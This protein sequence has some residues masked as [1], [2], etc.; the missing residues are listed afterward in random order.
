MFTFLQYAG[1]WYEFQRFPDIGEGH[2]EC[3]SYAFR[4]A[5]NSMIVTK[6]GTL[7]AG[8]FGK[9]F[10]R[11]NITDI[12][13]ATIPDRQ[14]PAEFNLVFG[15]RAL[16]VL[17]DAPHQKANYIIHD[18]DYKNYSVVFFCTQLDNFNLQNAY[19]LTR[20]RGVAPPNL[21]ELESKLTAAG[22][23]YLGVWY[24]YERFPAIF[25]ADLDCTSATYGDA[26]KAISVRNNGTLRIDLFGR[27]VILENNTISGMATVP[28]PD[29][30][31]EF[32]VNF[33][34]VPST[35]TP[36][37]IIQE[38]DYKNYSVIFSC[39]QL[40][41]L[42]LQFA[43]ILTRVRGLAPPNL[44]QLE[45]KLTAAGVDVTEFFVVDQKGC[46]GK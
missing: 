46:P 24:E 12:G 11:R 23:D 25:E 10:L 27:K 26:G 3:A 28:N 14:K 41:A 33:D 22:V 34:G 39:I 2:L 15:E 4:D 32:I 37:Y 44:A 45:N 43:W 42:N 5:L 7:K 16:W 17:T 21:A 6:R 20:V 40:E 29:K 18:T 19:I 9:T 8:L 30:P 13:V 1:M 38:T 31:A 35:K 36:N